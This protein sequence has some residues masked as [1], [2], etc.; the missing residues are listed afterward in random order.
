MRMG[1]PSFGDV[2]IFAGRADHDARYTQ[3]KIV[4]LR[5][6]EDRAVQHRSIGQWLTNPL[7]QLVGA[8]VDHLDSSIEGHIRRKGS[9]SGIVVDHPNDAGHAFLSHWADTLSN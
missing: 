6:G 2:A 9:E 3:Q 4:G 5:S 1:R 8:H 7:D